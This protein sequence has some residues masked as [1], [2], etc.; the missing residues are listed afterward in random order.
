MSVRKPAEVGQGTLGP[1]VKTIRER[2]PFNLAFAGVG[3]A[4]GK[5]QDGNCVPT[6]VINNISRGNSNKRN[7]QEAEAE[8]RYTLPGKCRK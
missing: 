2:L 6:V 3:V 5:A 1:G 4:Y 8:G 7:G